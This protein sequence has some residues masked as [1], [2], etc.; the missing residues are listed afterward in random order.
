MEGVVLES[1]PSWKCVE[2]VPAIHFAF[3]GDSAIRPRRASR[4]VSIHTAEGR[5]ESVDDGRME[6]TDGHDVALSFDL[7]D[8]IDL[9]PMRGTR[10]RLTL[11]DEPLANGPMGQLLTMSDGDGRTRMI[12]CY[13]AAHAG[14]H[15][16]GDM[17]VR[18]ALSQRSGGPVVFGTSQL[19][20]V[21]H[22]G[23]H[24]EVSDSSGS[25]IMHVVARTAAGYAAYV[26]VDRAL[27]RR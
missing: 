4:R 21:V 13:G 27:W 10:A 3:E 20:C 16:L 26:I 5:V 2:A 7:P 25:W 9:S 23:E 6:L 19:Q 24:V 11:R 12:A 15:V 18:V 14:D 1:H 17:H 8:A 22:V